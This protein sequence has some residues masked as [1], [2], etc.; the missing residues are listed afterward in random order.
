[1][2]LG[3]TSSRGDRV[4]CTAGPILTSDSHGTDGVFIDC[5]A[6]FQGMGSHILIENVTPSEIENTTVILIFGNQPEKANRK[7]IF[8]LHI[9]IKQPHDSYNL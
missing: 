6:L 1:M 7:Y 4:V 3:I 5:E 2:S 9:Q 8:W